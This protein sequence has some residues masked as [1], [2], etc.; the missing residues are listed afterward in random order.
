MEDLR[1]YKKQ[2][3]NRKSY[4]YL[5]YIKD[6]FFKHYKKLIIYIILANVLFNP[7]FTATLI[8][9]WINDFV[10]TIFEVVKK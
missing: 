9:N 1:K 4:N 5:N 8:G 10:Y 6:F 2:N 3:D 7:V